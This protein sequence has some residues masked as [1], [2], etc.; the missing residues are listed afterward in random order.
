MPYCRDNTRARRNGKEFKT[1]GSE[2]DRFSYPLFPYNYY[3]SCVSSPKI[4]I[5]ELITFSCFKSL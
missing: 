3:K 5:Y 1:T 4:N 2:I